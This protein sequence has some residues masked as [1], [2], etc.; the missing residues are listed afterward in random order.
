MFR[1]GKKG[2][3]SL[4]ITEIPHSAAII[5]VSFTSHSKWASI[6]RVWVSDLE[7]TP[8]LLSSPKSPCCIIEEEKSSTEGL[9]NP[10]D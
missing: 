8:D 2:Q 1:G 5:I 9:R 10:K 6:S 4:Q 3:C 7:F